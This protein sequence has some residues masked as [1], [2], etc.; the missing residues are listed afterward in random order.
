MAT[1][2]STR[3]HASNAS[4]SAHNTPTSLIGQLEALT[5]RAFPQDRSGKKQ[6]HR[7]RGEANR[8]TTIRKSNGRARLGFNLQ[9]A[10]RL[11]PEQYKAYE[12]CIPLSASDLLISS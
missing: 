8:K 4:I 5:Q 2:H 12:V 11:P 7:P 1:V 6:I 10:S 3:F 9:I